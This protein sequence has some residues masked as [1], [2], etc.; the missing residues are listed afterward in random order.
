MR[1][2]FTTDAIEPAGRFEAFRDAL[3]RGMFQFELEART[4]P[5]RGIVDVDVGGPVGFGRVFGSQA[6]FFRT[7]AMARR[8]EEGVW[9]LLTRT[10]LMRLIHGEVEREVAPG[11]G[12]VIN[13]VRPH[14]GQC[15]VDSDTWVIQ[16]PDGLLRAG[17]AGRDA[18]TLAMDAA[19]T[20]MMF[21]V[22][23]AH[24]RLAGAERDAI[25]GAT[26][27]YLADLVALAIGAD[28]DRIHLAG[29]R[30]ARA[31]RLQL[32]LD[33]IA[34]RHLDSRLR[35]EDVAKSLDI[36]PRYVHRLLEET[37]RSFSDHVLDHRLAFARRLLLD[38]QRRAMKVA[39]LA[40]ACGFADLS[41][42]NR[43]YRARFGESPTDTR[44]S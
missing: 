36:T 22:L 19:A 41:Y 23:E 30:G 14:A 32:V 3:A 8:C 31:A 28:A 24:H 33:E 5:Y 17:G 2:S 38:P 7:S 42:F 15:V 25:A 4:A 11:T 10:G 44:G 20:R 34:R 13:A 9:V 40:Y 39:D 35:A 18:V 26:G 37:G 16:V 27:L 29:H 1:L 43:T 6:E 12:V 21:G